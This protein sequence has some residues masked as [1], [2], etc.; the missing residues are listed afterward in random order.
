MNKKDFIKNA[1]ITHNNK[2]DYSK[3]IIDK[4]ID[5]ICPL[6]GLFT[7]HIYSH[8]RG[9]GCPKCKGWYKTTDDF[10]NESNKIHNDKYCYIS[11]IYKGSEIKIEIICTI[12]GV[13]RQTPSKHLQGQGCPNCKN[14][15]TQGDF[16][17]KSNIIHK[18]KYDYSLV[19]YN[20]TH[21]KV[22]IICPIHGVFYKTPHNHLSGQGCQKCSN[23]K[24]D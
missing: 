19:E 2:Y 14:T 6:H 23:K 9:S 22:K 15:I 20:S 21:N 8:L 12:H 11:S 24:R 13:F 7:Q 10:I 4:M 3:V 5:I 18:N 16:I 17:K 1:C